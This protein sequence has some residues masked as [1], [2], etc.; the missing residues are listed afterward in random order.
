MVQCV[1]SWMGDD[2]FLERVA[3]RVR[4]FVTMGDVVACSGVVVAKEEAGARTRVTVAL[5][6]T[7]QRGELVADGTAVAALAP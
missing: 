2:A 4:R 1:T 7:N 3:V 6:A 5:T